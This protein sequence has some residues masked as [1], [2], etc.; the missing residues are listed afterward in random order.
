MEP[1]QSSPYMLLVAP[2]QPAKRVDPSG[3]AEP[4]RGLDKLKECRSVVPAITH[5]D[6]SARVQTVDAQH[7]PRFHGLLSRFH[8]LTGSPMVINTS[9]KCAWG[10][11]RLYSR[12]RLSMLHGNEH[13]RPG[14]GTHRVA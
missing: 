3:E 13:G 7:A 11:D 5:V 14:D 1:G 6:Y 9:F 10:A 8:E 2:V 4:A 12:G